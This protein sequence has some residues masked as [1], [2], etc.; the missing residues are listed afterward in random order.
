[1]EPH[2]AITIA[3]YQATAASFRDGTWD[4]DV[5]QNRQALIQALPRNPGRILDLGCG[6]GRD[7]LA[8]KAD[9]HEPIGIDATPAFVA[10]AREA[11]GC[12]VWEQS[13][14]GLKLPDRHFD[15]IFANASLIHVPQAEMRRVLRDL[16][17]SLVPGGAMVMSIAR[18]EGEGYAQRPTGQRY[19]A[20]WEYDTLA[21][22]VTQAGFTILRHYYRPPGLPQAQQSWVVIVA[23][24]PIGGD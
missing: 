21:P 3:E 6:P 17:Q 20:F 5:S 4:H 7:L 12:E 19:T 23:Q 11:T 10:M 24:R 15:G 16:R 14:L 8:F 9:G 2:E 18:G 13:F 1:V 22:L